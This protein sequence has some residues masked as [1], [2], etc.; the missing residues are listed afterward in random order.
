MSKSMLS[1]IIW[2]IT[3]KCD[4]GCEYCGSADILNNT[5]EDYSN[6]YKIARM[7]S[8]YPPKSIN[9]SGGEPGCMVPEVLYD[10]VSI[11]N[12]A[13]IEVKLITNGKVFKNMV[14]E[15]FNHISLIGLSVN[16]LKDIEYIKENY[17]DDL[18]QYKD[19]LVII[20]NFGKHNIW[21]FD[22]I[23]AFTDEFGSS[24]QV[25]LTSGNNLNLPSSGI[26]QLWTMLEN[27]NTSYVLAD[28]LQPTHECQAGVQGCGITF[29]GYVMPCLSMR[30]WAKDEDIWDDK[31]VYN[32]LTNKDN[33]PLKHIWETQFRH[34]RFCDTCSCCRDDFKYPETFNPGD[35]STNINDYIL[36]GKISPQTSPIIMKYGVTVNDVSYSS[37]PDNETTTFKYGVSK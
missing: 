3:S 36:Q 18:K 9:I 33:N 32:L 17:L 15:F 29:D 4:K 25:Q 8:T 7:I 11:L 13:N 20:T 19:K 31:S 28:D 34:R 23:C 30:S 27:C 35:I 22:E 6:T 37:K 10:C 26:K 5:N 2:E 1:E 14:D 16:T 21:D 12:D 24:W